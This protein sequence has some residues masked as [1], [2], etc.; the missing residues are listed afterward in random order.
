ML[1]GFVLMVPVVRAAAKLVRPNVLFIFAD[2]WGWGDLSCHGN[3]MYETPNLDKLASQGT[4]YQAFTVDNP[5]CSPSRVAVETGQY[6]AR[7]SIHQHFA[8]IKQNVERNMPDWL[9]PRV[10]LLPRLLRQGGYATGHFGK[11]HLTNSGVPDAPL[12]T[13][14]G[15]DESAVF[16]GPGP[17]IGVDPN[18][19]QPLSTDAAIDF[20]RRHREQPFFVNLW[21]HT[22]HVPH[23]PT[24]RWLRRY[25]NLDE[26]HRVYAAVIS[27]ADERI[28]QVLAVLDE[29]KLTNNTLVVFSADNGPEVTGTIKQMKNASQAPVGRGTYYS[30]GTT[31]GMRGQKRSLFNGGVGVPFIVR[32]PGHTPV[33][34]VDKTTVLTA[35][36]LLPTFCAAAGI[37]L[38]TG[39][40]PDGQNVLP[41]LEG[42]PIT[43]QHPIFWDWRG[44]DDGENWPRLAVREGRWKLL[45]TLAGERVELYDMTIDRSQRHD[46]APQHP[47]EVDRL[48]AEV[49]AWRRDLPEH[50]DESA[51]SEARR[52]R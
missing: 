36:D 39:Y 9:D 20:I 40:L 5:V 51:L 16:N 48:V 21:I 1:L 49:L 25:R 6:P 52:S 11:W 13:A 43:R 31:G 38:P 33:G 50:P 27:E 12:P 44:P 17:Q 41:A 22:A 3:P 26:R 30:V 7:F 23:Y 32:W 29:L 4:D 24:P 45:M 18:S 2:D 46:V 35:V 34:A 47:D 28:G 19:D 42:R 15:Y 37:E 14:Y 10:V 8:A